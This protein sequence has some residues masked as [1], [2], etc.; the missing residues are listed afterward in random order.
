[1]EMMISD[2]YSR[3][4][5]AVAA[6]IRVRAAADAAR[7]AG[8]WHIVVRVQGP[9]PLG[10]SESFHP[11]LASGTEQKG[12]CLDPAVSE[13][14]AKS[15]AC[16][17]GCACATQQV[18]WRGIPCTHKLCRKDRGTGL[19]YIL[20]AALHGVFVYNGGVDGTLCAR[21]EEW[22]ELCVDRTFANPGTRH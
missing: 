21:R 16:V 20:R 7:I 10:S 8:P 13:W 19:V 18:F 12:F 14:W 5:I 9:H 1:M 22:V 2:L 17:Y 4:A 3:I 11:V 15:F 6:R